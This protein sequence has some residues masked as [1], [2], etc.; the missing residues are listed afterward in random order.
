[1]ASLTTPKEF[2][3][4]AGPEMTFLAYIGPSLDNISTGPQN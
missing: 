4:N 3:K 1:M 2:I